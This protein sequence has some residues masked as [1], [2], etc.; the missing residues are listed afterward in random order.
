[1]CVIDKSI[2]VIPLGQISD[3]KVGLQTGDNPS[4][5]YKDPDAL[6]SYRIVDHSKILSLDQ[7]EKISNNE[8]L[9]CKIINNGISN[10]LFEGKTIVPYDKGGSS[11]IEEGMLSN[12]YSPTKF[13]I[14]WS[15]KNV[16]RIKTLT[17]RDR[18]RSEG[19]KNITE[20]EEDK[21]ASRFQ[22]IEYYFKRGITISVRGLYSPTCRLNSCSIFDVMG[23]CLFNKYLSD[24]YVLGILCSRFCKY[25][26][27]CYLNNSVAVE[28]EDLKKIPIVMNNKL[29]K[30]II[31]DFV[32]KIIKKQHKD[33][34]YNYRDNEQ[35]EIDETVYDMYGLDTELIQECE[36]WYHRRYPKLVL[37]Y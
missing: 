22:N 32:K 18:K 28:V 35:L 20:S 12:Y 1:V 23:S 4:Y 2:Y 31:E 6:G 33:T 16:K 15:E 13:Y 24:E 25:M 3:I 30:K 10:D 21:I 36:D 9:R 26:I 8:E 19:Q 7:L 37:N 17:V 29:N 5:L 27:N 11:D 14:D 34:D